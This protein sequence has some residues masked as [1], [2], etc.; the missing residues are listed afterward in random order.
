MKTRGRSSSSCASNGTQ[1]SNG[2]FTSDTPKKSRKIR[3]SSSQSPSRKPKQIQS[4]LV[5]QRDTNVVDIEYEFGGPMGALGVVLGLPA[6]IYFLYFVCNKE[7]CVT[8]PMSF[9]WEAAWD[10]V[11]CCYK[12]F[13]STEATLIF[14]GWML[15]QILLERVLPG[16]VVEGTLLPNKTRLKYRLS[17]HL[18]WWVTALVLTHGWI[19]FSPLGELGL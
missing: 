2:D 7:L 13:F 3:K 9:D 6:V 1:K 4:N 8:N 11:P 15:F 12:G 18:Q 16:E 14:S 17:G 10:R 19:E 5:Q